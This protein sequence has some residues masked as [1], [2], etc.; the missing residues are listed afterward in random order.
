MG[1]ANSRI[2]TAGYGGGEGVYGF[3]KGPLKEYDDKVIVEI[4][5]SILMAQQGQLVLPRGADS[6]SQIA[7]PT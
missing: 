5:K 4:Y 7:C 3:G 6:R 1:F 2:C